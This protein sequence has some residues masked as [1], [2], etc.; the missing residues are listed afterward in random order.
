[1]EAVALAFPEPHADPAA[2]PT[3]ALSMLARADVKVVLTGEGG[4]EMFGGYRRYWALPFARG[5][6]AQTARKL[7][8]GAIA[9]RLGGRRI[10]QVAESV[11]SETGAAYL[12]YLTQLH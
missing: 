3:L 2:M 5:F 9:V 11:G 4:D 7:G 6:V 10:R 8:V 12:R 1:A